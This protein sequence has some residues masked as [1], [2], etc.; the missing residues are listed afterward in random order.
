MSFTDAQARD[1]CWFS[2]T[3]YTM[4]VYFGYPCFRVILGLILSTVL[5][6]LYN[7]ELR[8]NST[9]LNG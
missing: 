3:V 8:R 9:P 6:A 1:D 5:K 2:E 7:S 4:F